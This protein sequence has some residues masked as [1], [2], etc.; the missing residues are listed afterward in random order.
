MRYTIPI[1][2]L[3]AVFFG[4]NQ[5]TDSDSSGGV[6]P[7]SIDAT[8]TQQNNTPGIVTYLH[9]TGR[10]FVLVA[11]DGSDTVLDDD[12]SD[13]AQVTLSIGEPPSSVLQTPDEYN[14]TLTY[15]NESVQMVEVKIRPREGGAIT[16]DQV[17]FSSWDYSQ[18]QGRLWRY[19]YV[20]EAVSITGTG[21]KRQSSATA[22]YNVTLEKGWNTVHEEVDL[23][24]GNIIVTESDI[25]GGE[26]TCVGCND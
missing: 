15:S 26:W 18:D 3:T 8:I 21:T 7:L 6:E 19:V 20:T 23:S 17:V 16:T 4:C 25:P 24:N 5:P 14:S 9:P 2:V 1:F 22:N 10:D 11:D 13:D 12:T